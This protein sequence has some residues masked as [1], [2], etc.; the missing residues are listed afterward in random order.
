MER[1]LS[2]H[3]GHSRVS[4]RHEGPAKLE[5]R[6]RKTVAKQLL[7]GLIASTAAAAHPPASDVA[8]L[9]ARQTGHAPQVRHLTRPRPG[10]VCG[11]VRWIATAGGYG[12]WWPF[13]IINGRAQVGEFYREW[14]W[15]RN[16]GP[17]ERDFYRAH[18]PCIPPPPAWSTLK[19]RG[20]ILLTDLPEMRDERWS[21]WV[22]AR[23]TVGTNGSAIRCTVTRSSGHPPLDVRTCRTL[24]ARARFK[25]AI[26]NGGRPMQAN[27]PARIEWQ[28]GK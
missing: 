12:G 14:A 8:A 15:D 5:K 11:E 28:M 20:P 9:L 23:L 27:V 4:Y 13:H 16:P 25:P 7:I 21:G 6:M 10:L 24:M 26:T 2:T 17:L 3:C 18:R 22:F 19:R 1:Q